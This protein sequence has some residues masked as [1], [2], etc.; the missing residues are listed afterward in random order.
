[1]VQR[2]WS[3]LDHVDGCSASGGKGLCHALLGHRARA[4]PFSD[5]VFLF[6]PPVI[7]L[8]FACIM[9]DIFRPC[10]LLVFLLHL[11][12]VLSR[13]G[14]LCLAPFEGLSCFVFGSLLACLRSAST[15]VMR[16]GPVVLHTTRVEYRTPCCDTTP[17][18][19]CVPVR[20]HLVVCVC[21]EALG[22]WL[23]Q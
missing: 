21:I 9:L 4:C 19:V 3:V 8:C 16:T 6:F 12:G 20:V 5:V 11:P 23:R 15:A 10:C 18:V 7:V 1:M 2:V 14:R 22:D 13:G 17:G